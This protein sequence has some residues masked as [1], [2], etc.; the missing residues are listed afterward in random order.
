MGEYRLGAHVTN[1]V[2]LAEVLSGEVGL[3]KMYILNDQCI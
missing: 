2:R 3:G 1:M